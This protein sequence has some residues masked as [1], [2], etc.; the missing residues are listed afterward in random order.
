MSFSVKSTVGEF[1]FV[2]GGALLTSGVKSIILG[3]VR[4]DRFWNRG[5]QVFNFGAE[6]LNARI[7]VSFDQHGTEAHQGSAGFV[8]A[9][10]PNPAYWVDVPAAAM[11]V[12]AGSGAIA[13]TNIPSPWVRIVAQPTLASTTVSGYGQ[14]VGV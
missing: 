10:A 3:P 8:A 2:Q 4:A 7:E 13:Q 12:L 1:K 9:V 14:F 5:Y 6:T 11:T